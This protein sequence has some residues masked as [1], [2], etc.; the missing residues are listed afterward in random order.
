MELDELKQQWQA[1]DRK[2]DRS[3]TLNMRLLTEA[4]TRSSK[5]Q[6]LPLLL[7]QPLQALVGVSLVIFFA[8]FWSANLEAPALVAGGLMLHA[9]SI[10]LIIDAVMR[11]LLIMRINYAS[12]V[13]T[14]QRYLALLRRWEVRSFNWAWAG[15]WLATPAMLLVGVKLAAGVDLWAIWPAAVAWTAIGGAGGAAASFAFAR[16]A[17]RSPGRLGAALDRFYVGHS[18]ARAQAALDEIDEFAREQGEPR[19]P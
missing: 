6:L 11:M 12:P 9:L 7:L 16:W 2:L 13:L 19:S 18:I 5:R 4:R 1:L 8:R 14:I 17:R 10:G 3:L 15:C